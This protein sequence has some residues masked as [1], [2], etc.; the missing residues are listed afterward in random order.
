MTIDSRHPLLVL[1]GRRRECSGTL[2]EFLDLHA[3]GFRQRFDGLESR[4][5]IPALDPA[6]RVP[7]ELGKLRQSLLRQ[8]LSFAE[9]SNAYGDPVGDPWTWTFHSSLY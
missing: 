7:A 1:V 6:D 2:E 3:K 5:A 9:L 4:L 8:A